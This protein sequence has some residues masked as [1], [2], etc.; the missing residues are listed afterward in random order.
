MLGQVI[1]LARHRIGE[2]LREAPVA[3]ASGSNQY[4]ERSAPSNAPPTL[5]EQVGSPQRGVRLKKLPEVT[6]DDLLATA[7]KLWEA[8]KEATQSA[9]LKLIAG[10]ERKAKRADYEARAEKGCEIGDLVAMG[11]GERPTR[12]FV[13][14]EFSHCRGRLSS[15]AVTASA[16]AAARGAEMAY[17]RSAHCRAR[18]SSSTPLAL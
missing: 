7:A 6:R 2:E 15:S 18:L 13:S 16:S 14:N 10:D 5:T 3:R 1:L 12:C 17:E 4:K 8:G 11:L 9:V